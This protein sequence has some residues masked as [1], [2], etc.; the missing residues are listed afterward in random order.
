MDQDAFPLRVQKKGDV[1]HVEFRDPQ[2]ERVI[3][4]QIEQQISALIGQRDHPKVLIDFNQVEYLPT[5]G[6]GTLVAIHKWVCD[7]GGQLRLASLEGMIL[8]SLRITRLDQILNI[9]DDVES[10]RASFD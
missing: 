7:R 9:H 5:A 4:P 8:H 6:L 3:L 2:I 1:F 10:A